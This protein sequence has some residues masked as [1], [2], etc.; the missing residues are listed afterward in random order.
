MN[1]SESSGNTERRQRQSQHWIRELKTARLSTVKI[2][3]YIV[4]MSKENSRTGATMIWLS[5]G[6]RGIL[7]KLGLQLRYNRQVCMVHSCLETPHSPHSS[8]G[9]ESSTCSTFTSEHPGE[10]IVEEE[11]EIN[12][13]SRKIIGHMITNMIKIASHFIYLQ[14]AASVDDDLAIFVQPQIV[15]IGSFDF[16]KFFAVCKGVVL[17]SILYQS[18]V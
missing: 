5:Q 16:D 9:G 4:G 2:G 1:H 15:A 17:Y 3:N 8:E 14:R 10:I 12:L 11:I 6:Y 13:K 18:I 7:S